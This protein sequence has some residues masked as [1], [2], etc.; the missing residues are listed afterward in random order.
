MDHCIK[1]FVFVLLL[2]LFS[3]GVEGL[4]YGVDP[5]NQFNEVVMGKNMRELMLT[6]DYGKAGPNQRHEQGKGKSG[7]SGGGTNR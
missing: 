2:S 4:R 3:A 7:G 5:P 6:L 1:A